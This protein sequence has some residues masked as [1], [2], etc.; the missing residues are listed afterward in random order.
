M[1]PAQF[2]QGNAGDRAYRRLALEVQR[3]DLLA[4]VARCDVLSTGVDVPRR[5]A[6]LDVFLERAHSLNVEK[7]V[8]RPILLGRHLIAMG[9]VPGPAMGK[10]LAMAFEAQLDGEF[11]DLDGALRF[12]REHI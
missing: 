2:V 9:I 7:E 3:M 11:N 1:A 6:D 5:L 12:A 10:I 8:P 4:K